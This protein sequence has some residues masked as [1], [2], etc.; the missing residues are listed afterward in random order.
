MARPATRRAKPTA[1]AALVP[2][3]P[4]QDTGPFWSNVLTH[5]IVYRATS[6]PEVPFS[7]VL[8]VD[9]PNGE[10]M[11]VVTNFLFEAIKYIHFPYSPPVTLQRL[12]LPSPLPDYRLAGIGEHLLYRFMFLFSALRL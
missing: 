7:V 1:K 8:V 4:L 10:S 12:A 5:Q 2:H 3:P 11:I 6:D 9:P